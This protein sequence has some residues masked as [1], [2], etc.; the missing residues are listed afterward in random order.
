MPEVDSRQYAYPYLIASAADFPADFEIAFAPGFRSAIFLPRS[1][2]DWLGRRAY[3]PRT[4]IHRQGTIELVT[5]PSKMEPARRLAL[6]QIDYYELGQALLIG[7]LQFVA[8]DAPLRVPYNTRGYRV[9]DAFLGSFQQ[10]FFPD[11][12]PAAPGKFGPEIE[13]KLKNCLEATLLSGERVLASWSSPSSVTWSRRVF[14]IRKS[15]GGHLV[16]LTN[17][18]LLWITDQWKDGREPYGWIAR[19]APIDRVSALHFEEQA[20][21]L[22]CRLRSGVTWSI[23][24]SAE[25]RGSAESFA[26]FM[27][28]AL[29]QQTSSKRPS[30]EART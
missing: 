10:E 15:I 7:W 2:P 20:A 23:P 25:Q 19:S 11:D 8:G 22:V 9:I 18:R 26:R 5:H 17:R 1:D 12:R 21:M 14:R 13:L 3:P 28:A 27:A 16:A 30:G 29:T 4:L 24:V 6:D